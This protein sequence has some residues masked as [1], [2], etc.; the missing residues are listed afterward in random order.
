M[1]KL[2][3]R[4]CKTLGPGKHGD[5]DGLRL[6]VSLSLSRKWI[7]RYQLD[8]RRRDMGLGSYPEIGLSEARASAAEARALVSRRIDPIEARDASR[9]ASKSVPTFA[10]IAQIVIA[11]KQAR[12]KNAK[13]AYQ[14]ERHLGPAYCK[15]ILR[16]PINEISTTDLAK[17]L[18]PVWKKKPGVARKLFPA[19]R[20]VFNH[21]RVVLKADHG[22]VL[23]SPANWDDLKALG[24]EPAKELSRGRHP[25]LPH[26]QIGEF[27]IALRQRMSLSALMLEM[28]ILT[29]VRT[30]AILHVYWKHI[31][32]KKSI[33]TIP[34]ENLKDSKTRQDAFRVPL[35]PRVI[36]I[37][38]DIAKVQNRGLVFPSPSGEP[39]SDAVML[40]L[41]K[42]MNSGEQK[43]LDPDGRAIVP[44]GFRATFK[45]WG[46]ETRQDR[47]LIEAALGHVVGTKAERAYDR[48]DVLELRRDLM[49]A[50]ANYCEPKNLDNVIK[51]QKP[52]A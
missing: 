27:M 11:E 49:E 4:G 23:E 17:L 5:S 8:G 47:D 21:A 29:G 9:K 13:A 30:D 28:L 22:I 35:C 1:G 6:E 25:S 16:L 42:R 10:E 19:I 37:L 20:A 34:D 43:W 24:F 33:W 36:E 45:T 38:E 7:L 40:G 32:L 50:W 48:S 3:D 39:Y 18:K 46:R 12:T 44:H 31:D 26:E 15:P 2:T 14:V 51:F 52:S 41:L